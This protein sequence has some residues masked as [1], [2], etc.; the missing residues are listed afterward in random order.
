MR[1]SEREKIRVFNRVF[2]SLNSISR[3][4]SSSEL[5]RI[6]ICA[7]RAKQVTLFCLISRKKSISGEMGQQEAHCASSASLARCKEKRSAETS[8]TKKQRARRRS[9]T[10][11]VTDCFPLHLTRTPFIF[12]RRAFPFQVLRSRHI[13][14][15]ISSKD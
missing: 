15:E 11:N 9:P 8:T 1:A 10:E 5:S 2:C 4:Q 13:Y 3:D 14:F 6:P 7:A 12:D